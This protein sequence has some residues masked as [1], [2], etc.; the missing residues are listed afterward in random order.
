MKDSTCVL[1]CLHVQSKCTLTV[2]YWALLFSH[3]FLMECVLFAQ[4]ELVQCGVDGEA[5]LFEWGLSHNNLITSGNVD[6]RPDL[7]DNVLCYIIH[8]A[9]FKMHVLG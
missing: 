6:F 3:S 4:L 7:T 2:Q 9:H 1:L 8:L 5:I